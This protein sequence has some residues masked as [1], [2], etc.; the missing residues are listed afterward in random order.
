M[1]KIVLDKETI[2][3]REDEVP[4]EERETII[5]NFN[6]SENTIKLKP[7]SDEKLL[8]DTLTDLFGDNNG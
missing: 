7:I 8:E 3:I 6:D 5:S 2:Y 1:K 4:V